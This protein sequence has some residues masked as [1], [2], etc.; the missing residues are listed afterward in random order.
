MAT[1]K[2]SQFINLPPQKNPEICKILLLQKFFSNVN[3]E[4]VYFIW[5]KLENRKA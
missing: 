4:G 3:R 1:K 2:N 5:V